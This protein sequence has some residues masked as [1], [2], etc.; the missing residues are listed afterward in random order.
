MISQDACNEMG[1]GNEISKWADLRSNAKMQKLNDLQSNEI[2]IGSLTFGASESNE[3]TNP[4]DASVSSFKASVFMAARVS[5]S[6]SVRPT[7]ELDLRDGGPD[8]A[9]DPRL[10][11]LNAEDRVGLVRVGEGEV[12]FS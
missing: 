8:P 12:S 5:A 11:C 6:S 3:I 2:Q 9:S 7:P 1:N 10:A 4:L